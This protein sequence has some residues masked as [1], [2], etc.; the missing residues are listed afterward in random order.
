MAAGVN[1]K[2]SA[3]FVR[4]PFILKNTSQMTNCKP[5]LLKAIFI[6]IG[7][8]L[9]SF[10]ANSQEQNKKRMLRDTLDHKLDFS[11]FIID[12]KGFLPVAMIITEPALGG[13][14]LAAA[15]LFISPKKS[16]DPN[17]YTAPDI[18][19]AAAMYT[20]NK[21]WMLGAVHIGSWPKAGIKYRFGAFYGDIN[22]NFYP[23]VKDKEVKLDFNIRTV[24]VFASISKSISKND[25]HLGL[26]YVFLR[27]KLVPNFVDTIPAI[28]PEKDLDSH[29]AALGV[30]LD[31]DKRNS[32]FTPDKGIR[33]NMEYSVNDNWTGSDFEYQK[34]AGFVH[35]F[36]PIRSK[37]ISGLRLEGQQVFDTPPFFLNPTIIMRGI[38][39]LRYQGAST[40][41]AETE[42]RYDFNLRW[43]ALAFGGIA[44][45]VD[46]DQ[47][48]GD[49][50]TVYNAGVG[51]RYLVARAFKLRAGI[52][53]AIGP[54]SWGYYIVFGHNWNR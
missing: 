7:V 9:Q 23:T 14:G 50:K 49:G 3:I 21:S 17:K 45:V 5:I 54:D 15:P 36:V 12:A 46:K 31:W 2:K 37:W 40:V 1:L 16:P 29:A 13:I 30:F 18:T 38:P 51:F 33:A 6:F 34:L 24:P 39:A 44:Q 27:T 10:C 19:V 22:L 43:S 8:S 32:I 11:R 52:D 48:F 28:I 20:A 41:L 35:W 42:Q 47:S 53:V 25:I 26:K 4:G